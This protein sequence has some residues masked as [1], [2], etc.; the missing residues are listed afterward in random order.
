MLQVM[1]YGRQ[2][3]VRKVVELPLRPNYP[4]RRPPL[5]RYQEPEPYGNNDYE[6]N[7]D[8]YDPDNRY[9]E[10]ERENP[11]EQC[12]DILENNR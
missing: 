7:D 9:E 4:N 8:R 6:R 12:R 10:P 1:E 11:T 3:F 2:A 5:P